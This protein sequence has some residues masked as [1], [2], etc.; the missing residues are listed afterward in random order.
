MKKHLLFLVI[1]LFLAAFLRLWQL[2]EVPNGVTNDEANII[3]SAYSIF[4]TGRDITGKFLPLSFNI[5]NSFSPVYMYLTAPFVGILGMSPFSGRLPFAMMGVGSVILLFLITKKLFKSFDIALLSS[6]ALTISPW[7]LHVSRSAY[8]APVALFFY[9]LALYLF[10]QTVDKGNILWSLPAFTLGFYSYHSTKVFFL[11]FIPL[12]VFLYR[13]TLFRRKKETI[14]FLI[15]AAL[16][17]A[18]FVFVSQKEKVTRQQIFLWYD[19]ASAT[20]IVNWE[21]DINIAPFILRKIFNNKP[22][23]YL[24]VMRENYLEALSPQFLFIYGETSGLAGIYGVYFRGVMYIIELPLL[25]LGIIFLL[26]VKDKKSKL[27]LFSSLLISPLPSTFTVDKTYVMRSIMLLPFISIVIG[28][29]LSSFFKLI[30]RLQRVPKAIIVVAFIL[31]YTFLVGEYLYQYYFRYPVYGAE[32]WFKSSRDLAEYVRKNKNDFQNILV[33]GRVSILQYG[34]FNNINPEIIQ[35]VWKTPLPKIIEIENVAFIGDCLG[36]GKTY[37]PNESLPVK[38]LYIVPD[39]C[40]PGATPSA[41]IKDLGEPLRTIWKIY[42][43][44]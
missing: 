13:E 31:I 12:L 34:L 42:E 22:L 18:S 9:L 8:D 40:H 41:M 23:Y 26:K 30:E 20:K 14:L 1:I 10:L 33:A 29:G 44:K 25:I 21:R 37:D 24:R 6:L 5:D 4:K 27:F 15:S 7:H 3:Y 28:C 36:E 35:K 16:I 17:M 38:T 2:G 39:A 19:V 43:K 11:F 32:S